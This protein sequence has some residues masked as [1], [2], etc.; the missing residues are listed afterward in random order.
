MNIVIW[1]YK[2]GN[3]GAERVIA[4]LASCFSE[5]N[6][7]TILT[8][9]SDNDYGGNVS[10]NVNVIN[11]GKNVPHF[12][13]P[14]TLFCL[15][16][17]IKFIK[18]NKPDVIFTTGVQHSVII[19]ILSC[20]FRFSSKIIIRETNTIS[21]Q[22]QKSNNILDQ[23]GPKMARLFY[24]MAHYIIAPSNGVAEDLC[25][26]IKNI[27]HKIKVVF[28]PVDVERIQKQA[29]EPLANSIKEHK[30]YI[31]SV[32]RL[33]PQKGH[34]DLIKAWAPIYREKNIKLMILGD[35]SEKENLI[36]KATELKVQNGLLLPGFDNNP[37]PAMAHCE[38]FVLSSYYEGLPNT[39]LQALACGCRVV[40]TNCPSGPKEILQNG[41]FG[42]LVA[43]G[44]TS[45]L[46]IAIENALKSKKDTKATREML[47]AHFNKKN[48][49]KQYL[50]IFTSVQEKET[51]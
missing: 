51:A 32:G 42:E 48:I 40:S 45:A 1:I 24:P 16:G 22:S 25:A 46:N 21:A 33:V 6:N 31:L 39:L 34:A 3:G 29:Q 2:L 7:V 13:K 43:V 15:F 49:S 19:L 8:H 11:L 23:F 44:D 37:F 28:N 14:K 38:V 41:R 12:I 4:E 50:D 10:K 47:Q 20:V 30:P 18:S 9:T 36:Q 27:A 26:N 35:G 17:L 5:K